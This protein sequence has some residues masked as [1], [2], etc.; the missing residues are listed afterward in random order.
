MTV[1]NSKRSQKLQNPLIDRLVE[2][3]FSS[4]EAVIYVYLLE[5]GSET[6]G[7][8]IALGTG[9]RRQYVYVALSH[10]LEQGLVEHIPHGKQ[11]R[12]KARP[13]Y[14]LEKIGRKKAI[15][16]SDLA[17]DLNVVSAIGNDQSFEVIQGERA[18]WLH[19]TDLVGRA[20]ET[21]EC[22]IIGGDTAGYSRVMGEYLE[23]YLN[24]MEK[25]ELSVKYI[26]SMDEKALY[27]KQISR[28]ENQEYRFL[29]KLPK[30]VTHLVVRHD[31]VSF[32]SFLTPPLVYVVRSKVVAENYKQFFMMLWEMSE[33]SVK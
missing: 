28:F 4:A 9:F 7:S 14:E 29:D 20:D 5:K 26:G 11:A 18:I 3:G 16:A 19:E 32:Y 17:K 21:W 15:F 30:G 22:Y 13:P 1:K 25:K 12:Y 8:K 6:G 23:E 31:S 2:F 33:G 27:E 24:E 10:L